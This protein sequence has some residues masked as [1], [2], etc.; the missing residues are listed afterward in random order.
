[1]AYVSENQALSS[2]SDEVRDK[3][4][5]KKQYADVLSSVYGCTADFI[6]SE[7]LSSSVGDVVSF[8][9]RSDRVAGCGDFLEF[10]L[11]IESESKAKLHR[12]SFCRDR[13]CPMC[14][15]RKSMKM[16]SQM[17]KIMDDDEMKHFRFLFLTLTVKNCSAADLP[18]TIDALLS[19]WRFLYNKH[20]VFRCRGL[21]F[22]TFR[23][24][25]VTKN[26]VTGHYHPHL[27][28]VLAVKSEYFKRGYISQAEWT[29]IWKQSCKL[30]Y[31]P[32]V[33]IEK[34]DNKRKAVSEV[35]KYCV[36]GSD[37]LTGIV[38]EDCQ[39]VIDFLSAIKDRRLFGF[40]G[41][42]AKVR[43]RLA[44][45]DIENG[46]LVNI[47]QDAIREDLR[48]LIVRYQWR[49]G[50]YGLYSISDPVD[51]EALTNAV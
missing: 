18:D 43:K 35:S 8:R 38:I 36:K 12:A 7:Q 16:F 11:P 20:E 10:L 51:H 24:L 22:G 2:V 47:D 15:W 31:Q 44:L 45:D 25:E 21:I 26:H 50:F 19:G 27:H 32:I 42:F 3:W 1:M 23:T 46:D 48:Y 4:T 28:V 13:L 9:R 49:G 6:L 37:L 34:I 14:Q 5:D 41:I 30:E 17:S 29:E 39:T 40:T 33:H